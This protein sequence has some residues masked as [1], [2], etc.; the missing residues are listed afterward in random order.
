MRTNVTC[1]LLA[2]ATLGHARPIAEPT[3]AE[4][5][6]QAALAV[7]IKPIST[8]LT[9]DKADD[10]SLRYS[11]QKRYQ[12]LETTCSV[13]LLLKGEEKAESIKILHFGYAGRLPD[14]NGAVFMSFI[15]DPTLL[16][17]FPSDRNLKIDASRITPYA[18]GAPEYLA[19]LRRLPDGRYAAVTNHYNAG[20]SFRLLTTPWFSDRYD[21]RHE[22][23]KR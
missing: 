5:M 3:V 19:F 15:F 2:L 14:F 6:S 11:E 21:Q 4:L 18:K 13:S 12:A 20:L 22:A 17:A 16:V 1:I 10:E 23:P 8:R 7:I 9:D